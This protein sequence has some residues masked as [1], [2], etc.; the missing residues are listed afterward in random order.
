[1]RVKG[2]SQILKKTS[3]STTK[4]KNN[5]NLIKRPKE[6]FL[7]WSPMLSFLLVTTKF[8]LYFSSIKIT[9]L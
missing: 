3:P 2:K 6:H 5:G 9:C 8:L 1:M 4:E 7:L